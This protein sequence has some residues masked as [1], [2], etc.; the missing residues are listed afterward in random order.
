MII[1]SLK[2]D[3]KYEPGPYF[4]FSVDVSLTIAVTLLKKPMGLLCKVR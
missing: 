2:L 3:I 1:I 4:S